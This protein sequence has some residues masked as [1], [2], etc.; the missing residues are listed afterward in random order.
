MEHKTYEELTSLGTQKTTPHHLPD[1]AWFSLG[2][3][4]LFLGTVTFR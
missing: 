1:T 2:V 4:T 3:A